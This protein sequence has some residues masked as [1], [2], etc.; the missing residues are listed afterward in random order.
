M[1]SSTNPYNTPFINTDETIQLQ[2]GM[3]KEDV[4]NKIGDPLYVESGINS[5]IVWIYEVRSKEVLSDTDILANGVIYNKINA[6]TR[7]SSPIH[8]LKVVFNDN[9]VMQWEMIIKKEKS[10]PIIKAPI[11][12]ESKSPET[13]KQSKKNVEI[14]IKIDNQ[15]NWMLSPSLWLGSNLD[16]M[17]SGWGIS[18]VKGNL[19]FE[20]NFNSTVM[21]ENNKY[22]DG[23]FDGTYDSYSKSIKF[24]T[25]NWLIL[26]EKNFS[27]FTTRFG[28]GQSSIRSEVK[29]IQ[30]LEFNMAADTTG[31]GKSSEVF[32]RASIGKQF[33][34]KNINFTPMLEMNYF[35]E[36]VG[37]S[38]MTR[39]DFG[40]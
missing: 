29:N 10:T 2:L 30:Q 8:K 33:A 25:F 20:I 32:M 12:K 4:L 22:E 16:D 21:D 13:K 5:T 37:F 1:V 35:N 36:E 31:A 19:G 18:A 15:S 3:Q 11:K 40:R 39:F 6:N 38:L 17:G 7:H 23:N 14:D 28:F 34:Y 24:N 26:Y 27:N 9:K